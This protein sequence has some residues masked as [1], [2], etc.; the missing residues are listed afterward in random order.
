MELKTFVIYDIEDDKIR[1][2]I[3]ET[4][5]DYGLERIQHSAFLG[6]LNNNKREELFLKLSNIIKS[7]PGKLVIQPVCERDFKDQ[8]IIINEKRRDKDS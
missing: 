3:S 6:K 2:R 8:K 1:H 7:N 4:C 5:K